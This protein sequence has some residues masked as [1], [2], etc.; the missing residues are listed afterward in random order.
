[1]THPFAMRIDSSC[2]PKG[3]PRKSA[4]NHLVNTRLDSPR[5]R[6]GTGRLMI[7]VSQLTNHFHPLVMPPPFQNPPKLDIYTKDIIYIYFN[8]IYII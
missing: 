6:R 3:Q 5:G 7:G 1:M 2:T 4:I 8:N